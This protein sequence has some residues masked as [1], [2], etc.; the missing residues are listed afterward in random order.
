MFE[1]PGEIPEKEETTVERSKIEK[2]T[3]SSRQINLLAKVISKGE[4]REVQ[5]RRDGETHR[6]SD[7]LIAD[8]SGCVYMTLWDNDIDRVAESNVIDVKNAYISLFR[9][10]MRLSTG[11]YGSF[12]VSNEVLENVNTENNL[13]NRQFEQER[14]FSAPTFRPFHQGD[15]DFRRG[16][17]RRFRRR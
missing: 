12:E 11:R 7:T 15:R 5:S 9:G 8:D 10:S 13:S 17:G 4:P 16:G 2:L 1:E 6:V 3:P 14:R